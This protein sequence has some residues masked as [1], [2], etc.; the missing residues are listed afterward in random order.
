[1]TINVEVAKTGTENSASLL[2]RFTK[3]IQESGIINRVK[4]VRYKNRVQSPFKVKR[5]TLERIARRKKVEK[6]IKLGKLSPQFKR[7]R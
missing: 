1:M 5:S 4:S 3:R 7:R 6:L 2:R